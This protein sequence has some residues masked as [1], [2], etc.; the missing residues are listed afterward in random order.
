MPLSLMLI[1]RPSRAV[2]VVSIVA[3]ASLVEA[4]TTIGSLQSE[5]HTWL[6]PIARALVLVCTAYAAGVLAPI[7]GRGAPFGLALA[8]GGIV[9][10]AGAAALTAVL[11]GIGVAIVSVAG[12]LVAAGG[13]LLLVLASRRERE[14]PGWAP[15]ALLAGVGAVAFAGG[16]GG[17]V[18]LAVAWLAIAVAIHQSRQSVERLAPA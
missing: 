10:V 12:L 7:H 16:S 18:V 5:S 6:A 17:A 4:T 2:A 1:V 13:T 14:L 11:D 15:T 8:S 3:L 9:V